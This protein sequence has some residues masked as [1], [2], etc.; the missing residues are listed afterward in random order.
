M[1]QAIAEDRQQRNRLQ[2]QRREEELL[3]QVLD[4]IQ[5]LQNEGGRLTIAEVARK[6]HVSASILYDYPR[7]KTILESARKA[8]RAA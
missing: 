3:M 5:Q 4:A 8:Q 1:T 6:I 7:V 2:F